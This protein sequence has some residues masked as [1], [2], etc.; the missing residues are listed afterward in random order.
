MGKSDMPDFRGQSASS[1]EHK[2]NARQFVEI[3]Y[4]QIVLSIADITV[5]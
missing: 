4:P 1:R 3:S 5:V 2:Q